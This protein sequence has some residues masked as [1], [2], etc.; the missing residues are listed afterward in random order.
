MLRPSL[1]RLLASLAAVA[2]LLGAWPAAAAPSTAAASTPGAGRASLIVTLRPGTNTAATATEWQ[3]RGAEIDHVYS[4]A[5]SG[6]AGK[7]G[8][9]LAEQLRGDARVER[10]ERD[11]VARVSDTQTSPTWGLDRIDQRSRPLDGSYTY[12]RSGAGV[13]VYIFDTGVRAT[14][15]EFAGRVETGYTAIS[16]GHGTR[17]CH[18]HGT[19]VAGTVAGTTLA[20][21]RR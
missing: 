21:Q 8:P 15:V 12:D 6:F 18:G 16:D 3:S 9:E 7:V 5:L 1:R 11:G 13:V 20:S 2:S 19:H 4:H 14:H 17:D 10:V